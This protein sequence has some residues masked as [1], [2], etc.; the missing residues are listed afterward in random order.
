MLFFVEFE[1]QKVFLPIFDNS[2]KFTTN[3]KFF[4]ILSE[5]FSNQHAIIDVVECRTVNF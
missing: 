5:F 2:I 1:L 3:D 4:Q